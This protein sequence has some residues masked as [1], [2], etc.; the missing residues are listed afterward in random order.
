MIKESYY[1]YLCTKLQLSSPSRFGTTDGQRF[2][3][4]ALGKLEI[5]SRQSVSHISPPPFR[6]PSPKHYKRTDFEA[7]FIRSSEED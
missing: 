5:E 2:H 1:Y 4:N 7:V 3:W 6:S